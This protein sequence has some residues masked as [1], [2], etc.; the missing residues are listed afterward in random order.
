VITGTGVVSPIGSGQ[1][2]FFQSLSDGNSGIGPITRFDAETFEVQVAGEVKEAVELKGEECDAAT[3]DPKVGFALHAAEQAIRQAGLSGMGKGTLLHLG[4][5]L[6]LVNLDNVFYR[7]EV[8]IPSLVRQV[9]EETAPLPRITVNLAAHYI[10]RRYGDPE[11]LLM[12][13]SACAASA[14]AI[15][16]SFRALRGGRFETAVCGGF[17]S[18]VHPLGVG[19][20]QLLGA[21]TTNNERGAHACRPFDVARNGTVLGEGAAIFILETL[22]DALAGGKT[23]LAEICGYGSTLDAYNLSAPDPEGDGAARAMNLALED[24]GIEPEMIG[25]I[26]THGTGTRLNDEVEAMAIRR[27]FEKTWE[28][29]PVAATKAVTGHLVGAAGAVEL[30]ACLLPLLEGKLPPNP[31]LEKV[32]RGC[33]LYHVTE[34]GIKWDGEYV[35]SNSFGF[36]GQNATLILRSFDG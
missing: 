13:C 7:G 19:H 32:G 36:G 4:T 28:K 9:M 15:G 12:N 16:H 11:H 5:C 3:V 27:V 31:S 18:F 21:L 17:D 14:H 30:A 10:M 29:I 8:D 26:N 25:H 1:D 20:F 23:I 34:P 24:A 33:D 6:E 35:L 22:E 2:V